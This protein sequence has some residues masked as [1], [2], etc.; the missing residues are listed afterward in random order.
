[1][2]NAG[3]I[4]KMGLFIVDGI[5]AE[6]GKYGKQVGIYGLHVFSFSFHERLRQVHYL[7]NSLFCLDAL[8]LYVALYKGLRSVAW[9]V[10]LLKSL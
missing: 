5:G 2:K 7:G 10:A 1:M 6:K 3:H 4:Q 9:F 8:L